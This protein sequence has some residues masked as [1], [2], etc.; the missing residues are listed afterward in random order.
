MS[1]KFTVVLSPAML[2]MNPVPLMVSDVP[3]AAEPVATPELVVI[4]VTVGITG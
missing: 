3:P 4:P 1:T 2:L